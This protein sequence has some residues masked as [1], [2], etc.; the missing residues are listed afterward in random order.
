[1]YNDIRVAPNNLYGKEIRPLDE[2]RKQN[3]FEFSEFMKNPIQKEQHPQNTINLSSLGAPAGFC[4][5]VSML[6]REDA[7]AL[8]IIQLNSNPYLL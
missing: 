6:S 1:M 4:A 7:D 2:N 3:Q 8:G 5:D